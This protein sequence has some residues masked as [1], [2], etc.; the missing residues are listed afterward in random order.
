MPAAAVK[1]H[2]DRPSTSSFG[3][4][5]DRES[6]IAVHTMKKCFASGL[7]RRGVLGIHAVVNS[8]RTSHRTNRLRLLMR[9]TRAPRAQAWEHVTRGHGARGSTPNAPSECPAP[10]KL[11]TP[12]IRLR[13]ESRKTIVSAA[14]PSHPEHPSLRGLSGFVRVFGS[15][16]MRCSLLALRENFLCSLAGQGEQQSA[17]RNLQSR[18]QRLACLAK[19]VHVGG[20]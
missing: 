6:S 10:T 3:A 19:Q 7:V 20:R 9:Y 18:I 5:I 13:A 8:P 15:R 16:T 14:D 17:I 2:G 11:I 1:V 12:N 4:K